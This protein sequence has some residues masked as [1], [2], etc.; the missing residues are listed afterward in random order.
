LTIALHAAQHGPQG[1]N[2]RADAE[3][4]VARLPQSTWAKAAALAAE[5][6]AIPA[7]A[8][9]IR[10][11]PGGEALLYDL[12]VVA[13]PTVDLT[14]RAA[15]D[16]P[17]LRGLA[18][19][20]QTPGIAS[21]ARLMVRELF[22]TPTFMRE[23]SRSAAQGRLGLFAAYAVRPFWLAWRFIPAYRA[24]RRARRATK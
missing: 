6:D 16:V 3:R 10:A 13:E 19:L 12:R 20:D 4:A 1:S 24:Y 23:W 14:V 22:P 2:P 17:M 5:L 11:V 18:Q 15:G 21:K 9:G 8:A 7:F